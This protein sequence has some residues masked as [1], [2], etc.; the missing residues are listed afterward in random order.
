MVAGGVVSPLA[1]VCASAAD[2]EPTPPPLLP[3]QAAAAVA[4][5][6]DLEG[7]PLV[8]LYKKAL[9]NTWRGLYLVFL[10][11]TSHP[12]V[13]CILHLNPSK[14]EEAATMAD[15]YEDD[16]GPPRSSRISSSSEHKRA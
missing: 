4:C 11:S 3:T 10:L 1:A 14:K 13:V 2:A 6:R 16:R 12:P 5:C 9:G 7:A 8:Q 15:G